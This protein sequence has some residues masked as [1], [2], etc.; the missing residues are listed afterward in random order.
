MSPAAGFFDAVILAGGSSR[1][2][3]NRDKALITF[4]GRTFLERA[5]TA[6]QAASGSVV[7]GPRRPGFSKVIWIEESRPSGP[8]SALRDG[9][10]ATNRDVIVVLAVDMP[11]VSA[12]EVQALVAALTERHYDG[13]VLAQREG[14]P[15]FLAGAYRRV[16]LLDRLEKTTVD[17]ARLS[18]VMA[19]LRVGELISEVA[20]DCDS[21][22]ELQVLEEE[23]HQR[24]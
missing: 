9:V 17:G 5:L 7:V 14:E 19:D 6:V 16:P 23:Q 21:P 22:E 1:R 4:A 20:R 12:A 18:D 10:R 2:F 8:A 3:G 15:Q 11:L 24:R 13:V